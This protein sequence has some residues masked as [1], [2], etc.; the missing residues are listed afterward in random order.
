[1]PASLLHR[2]HNQ[3]GLVEKRAKLQRLTGGGYSLTGAGIRG[4]A[5]ANINRTNLVQDVIA[6]IQD[7]GNLE[8]GITFQYVGEQG[9]DLNGIKRD[10]F[11]LFWRQARYRFLEGI[12]NS[13]VPRTTV[14]LENNTF[15]LREP[16]IWLHLSGHLSSLH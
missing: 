12:D 16:I 7:L 4:I 13:F 8:Q 11:T 14:W 2:A 9:V 5:L 3:L 10:V 15:S 6:F 1:M